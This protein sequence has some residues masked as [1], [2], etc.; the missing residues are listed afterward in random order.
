VS[1]EELAAAGLFDPATQSPRRADLVRRCLHLGLTLD[2][3]R[4]AGD[5]LIRHAIDAIHRRG[6]EQLTIAEIGRRAGLDNATIAMIAHATGFAGISEHRRVWNE[7]DVGAMTNLAASVELLGEEAAMQVLRVSTA[8]IGRIGDSLISTFITTAGAP[9]MAEDDSG[10]GLLEANEAGAELLQEFGDWLASGLNR[11]LRVALRDS[12]E[13]EMATAIADGVDTPVMAIGFADLVGSTSHAERSSL[14]ELNTALQR[15][16]V[17][18]SDI[19]SAHGGRI[20]K[21][22]GDEVMFRAHDAETAVAIAL[23]LSS[24]IEADAELPPLRSGVNYGMV[25]SREGDYYGPTVNLA[26][27][28]AKLAPVNGVV[29]PQAIADVIAPQM[30]CHL[31]PL[32]T[33]EIPGLQD[34]VDLTALRGT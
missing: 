2:E 11:Y 33:I 12:T 9:A 8:A 10:L 29:V 1:D 18:S 34:P 30:T 20:V 3:I 6:D 19:V 32:G 26:A 5:D 22:I 16:E 21:F 17:T 23:E 25:L 24:A 31:D 7:F 4:A 14:V 27:R 13:A 15:F 28:I